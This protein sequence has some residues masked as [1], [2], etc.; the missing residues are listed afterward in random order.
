M[1]M[2]TSWPH[3]GNA[4]AVAED[5]SQQQIPIILLE[6]PQVIRGYRGLPYFSTVSVQ[7]IQA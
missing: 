6:M 4:G 5:W 1:K 2:R 3:L 7:I